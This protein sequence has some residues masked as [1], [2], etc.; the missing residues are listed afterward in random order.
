MSATSLPWLIELPDL[1]QRIAQAR[2]EHPDF[3]GLMAL[4]N[5]RLNFLP[6]RLPG[7]WPSR[8]GSRFWGLPPPSICMPGSESRRCGGGCMLRSMSRITGNI[9]R[10]C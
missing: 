8:F 2:K 3:A 7:C 10:N 1:S 6:R 5:T 9:G 4:A